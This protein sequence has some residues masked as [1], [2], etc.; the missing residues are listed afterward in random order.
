MFS[1]NIPKLHSIAYLLSVH[2]NYYVEIHCVGVVVIQREILVVHEHGDVSRQRIVIRSEQI[3]QF[4]IGDG[5]RHRLHLL[6]RNLSFHVLFFD[7]L[8]I[9][10]C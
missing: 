3:G 6:Q 5:P 1:K 8:V 7:P 9:F 2:V 10:Y 4:W